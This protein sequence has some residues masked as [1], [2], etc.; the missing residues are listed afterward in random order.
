MGQRYARQPA[1][2]RRYP[3]IAGAEGTAGAGGRELQLPSEHH[4]AAVPIRNRDS[5]FTP[6]FDAAFAAADIRIIRTW[7]A[8]RE[9]PRSLSARSAPSDANASTTY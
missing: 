2:T 4:A 5:K 1:T 8:H 9:R 3:A 7:H 6:A